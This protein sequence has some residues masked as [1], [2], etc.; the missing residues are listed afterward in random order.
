VFPK[1]GHQ[2]VFMGKNAHRDVFPLILNELER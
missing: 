2:D 1:Y